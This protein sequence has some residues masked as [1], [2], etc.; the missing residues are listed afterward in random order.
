M[1]SAFSVLN[2][3][4]SSNQCMQ[5]LLLMVW[6]VAGGRLV[7]DIAATGKA[8]LRSKCRRQQCQG[9]C[10]HRAVNSQ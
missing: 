6:C 4:S 9:T 10:T 7:C 2:M 1:P 5:M 8:D 3:L